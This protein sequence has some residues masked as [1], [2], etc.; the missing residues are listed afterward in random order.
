MAEFA[1]NNRKHSTLKI[2][3]FYVYHGCEPRT[4][5]PAEIKFKIPALSMYGHYM[6]G[7]QYRL[8]KQLEMVQKAMSKYYDKK[9][10]SIEG[11]TKGDLVVVNRKIIR[12]YGRCQK[13]DNIMYGHFTI[14][15]RGH[16]NHDCTL[17]PSVA[18]KIHLTFNILFLEK[19]RDKNPDREVIEIEADK[20]GEKMEK[21]IASGP[22]NH[23]AS[24]HVYLCI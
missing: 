9:T 23:H 10:R 24:N 12:L 3:P 7:I 20:A 17:K 16:N 18:L 14:L 22:S 1:Y 13:L 19:S 4:N 8:S 6:T 5:W 11:F 2:M 21:I 15:S